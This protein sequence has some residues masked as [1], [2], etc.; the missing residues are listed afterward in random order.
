MNRVILTV[1]LFGLVLAGMAFANCRVQGELTGHS[2]HFSVGLQTQPAAVIVGE[3]FSLKLTACHAD[4]TP[5]TGDIRPSAV[6]PAHQHGMNYQPTVSKVAPGEYQLDGY[7]FHM[8]GDWQFQF[9]MESG[10][11]FETVTVD[12]QP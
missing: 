3:V 2:D 10:D 7:L 6:M 8:P 9:R 5:F 1:P 12:Y 4:G 11:L